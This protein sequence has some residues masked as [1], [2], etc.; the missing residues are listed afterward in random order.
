MRYLLVADI[1]K[2]NG[3]YQSA[4]LEITVPKGV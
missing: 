2:K 1:A 4:V 3:I